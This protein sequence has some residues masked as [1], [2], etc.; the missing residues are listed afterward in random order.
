M[1][2]I[3]KTFTC[4]ALDIHLFTGEICDFKVEA[5]ETQ[6]PSDSK[7]NWNVNTQSIDQIDV[8]PEPFCVC[9]Y[10]IEWVVM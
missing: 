8:W 3:R 4:R 1:K 2:E 6:S 9:S 7:L 10:Q 5:S